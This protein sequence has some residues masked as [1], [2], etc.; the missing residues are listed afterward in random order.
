MRASTGAAL[1]AHLVAA[2]FEDVVF[3]T[4]TQVQKDGRTYPIFLVTAR[5]PG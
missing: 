1:G 5:R 2:G 4:A 3:E